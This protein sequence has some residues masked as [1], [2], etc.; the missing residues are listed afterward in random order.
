MAGSRRLVHLFTALCVFLCGSA[1][2]SG[3]KR[4]NSEK[5]NYKCL[6]LA[7]LPVVG[8]C[9]GSLLMTDGL[10]T[11]RL[12]SI[13]LSYRGRAALNSFPIGSVCSIKILW[14]F[15]LGSADH[16][17]PPRHQSRPVERNTS[18]VN[19]LCVLV[20]PGLIHG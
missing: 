13:S 14:H 20:T 18:G 10:L 4:G 5:C 3:G 16:L 2:V 11:D 15:L 1:S 19:D 12:P 6:S 9:L 17:P 7:F 8:P